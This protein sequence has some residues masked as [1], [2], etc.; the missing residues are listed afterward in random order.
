LGL[1]KQSQGGKYFLLHDG[2]AST[3]EEAISLHGGEAL[4]SKNAFEQLSIQEKTKLV[5]FLESL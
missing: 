3:L 1:S 5:R 2:R 4:S